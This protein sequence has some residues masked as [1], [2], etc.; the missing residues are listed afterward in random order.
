MW[1]GGWGVG[2]EREFSLKVGGGGGRLGQ[3]CPSPQPHLGSSIF[4]KGPSADHP[5]GPMLPRSL[6]GLPGPSSQPRDIVTLRI[7][8]NFAA[9]QGG[10]LLTNRLGPV[11]PQIHLPSL[12]DPK[13]WAMYSGEPYAVYSL[14]GGPPLQP[15]LGRPGSHLLRAMRDPCPDPAHLPP[16]GKSV[17]LLNTC[18]GE[19]KR[20][21]WLPSGHV[22]KWQRTSEKFHDGGQSGCCDD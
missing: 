6:T 17:R 2:S 19:E 16:Y 21:C 11:L 1:V 20:T 22:N 13:F 5:P 8:K 7:S 10:L 4:R 3:G 14:I 12:R 9:T 18:S 15:G